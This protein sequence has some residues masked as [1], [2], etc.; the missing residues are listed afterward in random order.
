MT[1]RDKL[2]YVIIDYGSAMAGVVG[3]LRHSAMRRDASTAR[4]IL[5]GIVVSLVAVIMQ[6]RKVKLHRN[7]NHNDL[8]VIQISACCLFYKGGRLLEDN[9]ERIEGS[10]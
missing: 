1:L 5:G 3:L 4:C 10:T 2:L 7:F 8:Y 9:K 6:M